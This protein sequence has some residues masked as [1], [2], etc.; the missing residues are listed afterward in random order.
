LDELYFFVSGMERDL[1][2]SVQALINCGHAGSCN[3]GDAHAANRYLYTHGIPDTTCQQYQAKNME[4]SGRLLVKH[5]YGADLSSMML[6]QRYQHLH[7]LRT[8]YWLL[9][10]QYHV[11]KSCLT[12]HSFIQYAARCNLQLHENLR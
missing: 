2:P 10:V 12:T 1:I 3:G 9:Y 4:V 5:F 6:V 8:R 7:E 11:M